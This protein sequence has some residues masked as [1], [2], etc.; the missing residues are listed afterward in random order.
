MFCYRNELN[1]CDKT[2]PKYLKTKKKQMLGH[3]ITYK[4]SNISKKMRVFNN[5]MLIELK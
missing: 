2:S 1:F 3:D 5:R 4:V